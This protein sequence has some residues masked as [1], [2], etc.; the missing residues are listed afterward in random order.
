M[1]KYQHLYVII[2]HEDGKPVPVSLEML[3]E[4]RRLMD[5]Y[6][7]KYSADEKV[8]AVVL[9]HDVRR[10]CEE[11]IF[12]GADAV[13]YAD[14]PELRYARNLIDT[15]V[16]SR[17]ATSKELAAKF[18]DA[19]EFVRPRY[20]F[21]AADSIGRHLSSTVLAEL[22]SGLASDINKLVIEDLEIKHEHKTK[23]QPMK[24]ERTL[25]MY[26]PDFSGF[27]W[28]T[29]L[30][31]DNRNPAIER[32]YHPQACSIIPGVFAPI[33]R[34]STRRGP[35]VDYVPK[36]DECDLRVKIINRKIVKSTVDFDSKKAIVSFGRGIKDSPEENIKLVAELAREL[37]AEVGISLPISKKPFA[38]SEGTSSTY[39][40]PDRVI[41]TSGRKVA[42]LLYVAAGISG[43]MQHIAGMK[44]A[45]FVVAINP[46][47]DSP[48]KDECDIFIK[49]RMEDVIPLLLEELRKQKPAI[50]VKK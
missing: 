19:S 45:G 30:C 14:S 23:G 24:Y 20:M 8:V 50:E 34:D 46:D 17:I 43:A 4:A 37:E 3:G 35:I 12:Y 44:E 48:I 5:G 22:E 1:K 28:T 31:L 41:G 16:I 9:G 26:R 2:E 27:L 18:S 40:I 21:F 10:L 33:E 32:D 39:M 15:K 29:I 38:V 42:P 6:N 11:L 47:E 25:E 13:I 7:K 36:F 49:G